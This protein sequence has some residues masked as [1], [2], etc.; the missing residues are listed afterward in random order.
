MCVQRAFL[1]WFWQAREEEELVLLL[2]MV[3]FVFA[4]SNIS[5]YISS[6]KYASRHKWALKFKLTLTQ[7][8]FACTVA[9]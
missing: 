8:Y 6:A 9:H 3:G 1:F 4:F 5:T 2:F 7:I